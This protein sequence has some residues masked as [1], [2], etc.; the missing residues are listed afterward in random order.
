[1]FRTEH[2]RRERCDVRVLAELHKPRCSHALLV[3]N[4]R[5]ARHQCF[6]RDSKEVARSSFDI[7]S[8]LGYVLQANSGRTIR[9]WGSI[10][11]AFAASIVTSSN[12]RKRPSLEAGAPFRK[13]LSH[14]LSIGCDCKYGN[15]TFGSQIHRSRERSRHAPAFPF[16]PLRHRRRRAELPAVLALPRDEEHDNNEVLFEP[17]SDRARVP[18]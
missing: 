17:P 5:A 14:S 18:A 12:N 10:D 6:F 13:A 3:D 4:W 15:A 16:D 7:G 11:T 1:M 8:S 9:C 2:A